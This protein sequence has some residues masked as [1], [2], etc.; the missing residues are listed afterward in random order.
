MEQTSNPN[1]SPNLEGPKESP[2]WK[3]F[4]IV[5]VGLLILGGVFYGYVRYM[6]K[7]EVGSR[8]PELNIDQTADW[9]TY[10]NTEYGFSLNFND[11]WRGYTILSQEW[12]GELIGF[13]TVVERGPKIIFRHPSW[14]ENNPYEDI[15]IMIFTLS[16]WNLILGDKISVS[17]APVGPVKLAENSKYVFALP[18]RYNYDYAIGWEEADQIVHTLKAYQ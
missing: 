15:P 18:P 16:Q 14:T 2:I 12:A 9:K 17:A 7:K 4:I 8:P 5:L 13:N 11:D 3:N 10:I 6:Q 1:G